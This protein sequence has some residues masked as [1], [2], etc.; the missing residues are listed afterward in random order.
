MAT[1][2]IQ[3]NDLLAA[4]ALHGDDAPLLARAIV[5][6]MTETAEAITGA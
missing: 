4:V 5:E 2:P 3:P 1:V 6:W